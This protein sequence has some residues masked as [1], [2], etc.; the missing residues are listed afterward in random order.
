MALKWGKRSIHMIMFF[1]KKEG[2]NKPLFV[3]VTSWQAVGF[4][5][6][7]QVYCLCSTAMK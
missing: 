3:I 7:I 5:S 6:L 1:G 2:E 4:V